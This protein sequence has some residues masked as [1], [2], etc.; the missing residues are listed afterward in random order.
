MANILTKLSQYG[1]VGTVH[2]KVAMRRPTVTRATILRAFKAERRTP[3]HE[4][5]V[6]IGKEVLDAHEL[7]IAE[8]IK[9]TA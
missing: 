1:L 9:K 2:E 8:E 3:V 4:M 6:S 7:A 5:I